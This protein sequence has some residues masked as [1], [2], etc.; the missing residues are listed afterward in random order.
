MLFNCVSLFL[1]YKLEILLLNEYFTQS[2]IREWEYDLKVAGMYFLLFCDLIMQ[3]LSSVAFVS[4][5]VTVF[6]ED[7]L[8]KGS[9]FLK[10]KQRR[11]IAENPLNKP[12]NDDLFSEL[13]LLSPPLLSAPLL[14]WPLALVYFGKSH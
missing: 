3:K 12:S 13:L 14:A 9:I 8:S 11:T 4:E 6:V 10:Q 7:T 5:S 1:P 2:I